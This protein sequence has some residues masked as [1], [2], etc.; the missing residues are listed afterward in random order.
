MKELLIIRSVSF[1]QLDLNLEKIMEQ[2]PGYRISLLTHEH[3]VKLAEKYDKIEEIH[4]YDYKAGFGWSRKAGSLKGKR[5]AAVVIPVTNI[6]GAGFSNVLLF[7][8]TVKTERRYLCNVVSEIRELSVPGIL[9]GLL[10]RGIYRGLAACFT[11]ITLVLLAPFVIIMIVAR[12][13][14]Y[15]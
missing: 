3:G 10:L 11:L 13:A 1:Q 9:A 5:F 14:N 4:V 6:S 15:V 2:F 12:R 7:S 8:L